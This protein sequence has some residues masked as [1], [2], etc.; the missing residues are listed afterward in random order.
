MRK[1]AFHLICIVLSNKAKS[2][3]KRKKLPVHVT[4]ASLQYLILSAVACYYGFLKSLSQYNHYINIIIIIINH[5][6]IMGSSKVFPSIIMI[7][8]M[9][10]WTKSGAWFY[11]FIQQAGMFQ[12]NA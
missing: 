6:V 10:E 11:F 3:R 1:V 7:L 2:K 8:L 12:R 4:P 5:Y 9:D